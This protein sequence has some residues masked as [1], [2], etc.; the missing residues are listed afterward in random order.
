MYLLKGTN[1]HLQLYRMFHKCMMAQFLENCII[2]EAVD[3]SSTS[4][5]I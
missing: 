5:S 1:F 3:A 2:Y 4:N